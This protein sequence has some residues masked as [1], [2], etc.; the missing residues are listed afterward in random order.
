MT[1]EPTPSLYIQRPPCAAHLANPPFTHFF[2]CLLLYHSTM[3]SQF[4]DPRPYTFDD[5][6]GH[7]A[8][9]HSSHHSSDYS[10]TTPAYPHYD[11]SYYV[12]SAIGAMADSSSGYYRGVSPVSNVRHNNSSHSRYYSSDLYTTDHRS[13]SSSS[14]FIP[15]P[16]DMAHSYNNYSSGLIPRSPTSSSVERYATT[17]PY[18]SPH[19]MTGSLGGGHRPR[20]S[21]S[22]PRSGTLGSTGSTTS[23]TG[24]RFP[25]EKCGKT[26]SRSH[27]RKRHHETQ[28]LASPIIHRCRFCEKEFSR[29][30][31]LK[32]HV[33]N[34]CD[35][36][37][38]HQ[39]Q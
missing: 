37:P 12:T 34:G 24:E 7:Y 32:R 17:L 8:S 9:A 31:S 4:R 19:M 39:R 5:P 21:T 13:S 36:A 35:E 27:D 30:D 22:R 23:P 11:A 10:L 29:A 2:T 15:T 20:V 16:S 25:C 38:Q 6:T 1:G 14:S 3:Q 33:D 26:F 28:H 18:P